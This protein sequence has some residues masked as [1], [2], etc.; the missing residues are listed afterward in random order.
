MHQLNHIIKIKNLEQVGMVVQDITTSMQSMWDT[1][2]IG[3]WDVYVYEPEI[4][5]DVLYYNN[6]SKSGMKVA[7]TKVGKCEIELVESIG[8]D[9][10]YQDFAN[11]YGNGIQHLGWHV[12][13]SEEEFFTTMQAM[14]KAGFP[15]IWSGRSPRGRFAYFDTAS[16]LH[17]LLEMAWI[18]KDSSHVPPTYVFPE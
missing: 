17:T 4:L 5:Q 1:F 3:P 13:E 7:R 6:P 8:Q 10:I 18:D 12:V 2:G 15:C 16:V 9:N 11:K 14:E